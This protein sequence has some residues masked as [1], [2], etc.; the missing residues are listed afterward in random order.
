MRRCAAL[1]SGRRAVRLDVAFPS[2]PSR[3]KVIRIRIQ[4]TASVIVVDAI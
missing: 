2:R 4:P 3:R 1:R